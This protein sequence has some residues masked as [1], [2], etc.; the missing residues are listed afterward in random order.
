MSENTF[1]NAFFFYIFKVKILQ[2]HTGNNF[3]QPSLCE[4]LKMQQVLSFSIATLII[5]IN[6]V[7]VHHHDWILIVL[8][9]KCSTQCYRDWAV[10]LKLRYAKDFFYYL[11][12][13]FQESNTLRIN[14]K[15]VQNVKPIKLQN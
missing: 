8:N 12:Q 11:E 14:S 10:I 15:R 1:K 9:I 13:F 7:R 4:Q 3:N 2:H 5:L 6:R